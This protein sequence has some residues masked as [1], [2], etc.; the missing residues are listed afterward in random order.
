VRHKAI[1][2]LAAIAPLLAALVV[3]CLVLK[4]FEVPSNAAWESRGYAT[5]LVAILAVLATVAGWLANKRHTRSDR[6]AKLYEACLQL[7][8]QVDELCPDV[9]L[10]DVGIH[11]WLAHG[12]GKRRVLERGPQFLLRNRRRSGITLTPNKGVVGRAWSEKADVLLDLE[13]HVHPAAST[14]AG[15]E[16]LPSD[17]RLGIEWDE[18]QRT[19]HYQ[20]IWASA[21]VEKGRVLAVVSIDISASGAFAQL[22]AAAGSEHIRTILGTCQDALASATS[23]GKP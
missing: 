13:T 11:F 2:S 23:R 21:L 10:K 18:Y 6:D 7:A 12:L 4:T 16:A 8:A 15:Y 1:G 20:A 14:R 22:E 9:S 19:K 5:I 17:Y 3:F